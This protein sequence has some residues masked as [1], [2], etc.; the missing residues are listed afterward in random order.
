MSKAVYPDIK[1]LPVTVYDLLRYSGGTGYRPD[2]EKRRLAEENLERARSAAKP[3]FIYAIYERGSLEYEKFVSESRPGG[4]TGCAGKFL[5][6]AV[7][8][9]GPGLDIE[10]SRLMKQGKALDS[11]FA[12]AGGIAILES[13][14]DRA[15]S[16]LN[17]EAAPKGLFAGCRSGP[18]YGDVPIGFQKRLIDY[19]NPV[20]IGV[21]VNGSGVLFP[22]KSLSFWT[23]WSTEPVHERSTYKCLNCRL[24]DCTHRVG[25]PRE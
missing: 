19:V 11:L 2:A 22:L 14:S 12:D 23:E 3:A 16:H 6:A 7:C 4:K 10:T 21:R 17:E 1:D 8:T 15:Y 13:L 24:K 9:I 25:K 20:K 5:A 18:G